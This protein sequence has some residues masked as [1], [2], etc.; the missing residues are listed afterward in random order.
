MSETL[1]AQSADERAKGSGSYTA[2]VLPV[3]SDRYR[4]LLGWAA[5]LGLP[6]GPGLVNGWTAISPI[7]EEGLVC[8]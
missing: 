8:A 5:E 6:G 2:A 7:L 3:D 1:P 4:C